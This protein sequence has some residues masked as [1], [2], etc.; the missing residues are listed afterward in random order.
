MQRSQIKYTTLVHLYLLI[1]I[2]FFTFHVWHAEL[3]KCAQEF[4]LDRVLA[5][6]HYFRCHDYIELVALVNIL[7]EFISQHPKVYN[8]HNVCSWASF[9]PVLEFVIWSWFKLQASSWARLNQLVL[10]LVWRFK[11]SFE[12]GSRFKPVLELG[13]TSFE[14]SSRFKPA[15]VMCDVQK[16]LCKLVV[17]HCLITKP[18]SSRNA[19]TKLFKDERFHLAD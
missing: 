12:P 13:W 14:A 7:H 19:K 2:A 1:K 17:S 11:H 15:C 4:T 18:L 16:W 9:K 3:M 10:E 6:I 5:G 8:L